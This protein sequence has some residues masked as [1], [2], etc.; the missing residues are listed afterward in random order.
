MSDIQLDG[1]NRLLKGIPVSEGISIAHIHVYNN[2]PHR[3]VSRQKIKPSQIK[4]EKQALKAAISQAIIDLEMLRGKVQVTLDE[5]H[6][7]IFDPQI[8]FLQDQDFLQRIMER[9]TKDRDNA[10]WSLM[11]EIKYFADQFS[12]INDEFLA[13]RSSDILDVGN[14]VCQ[15]LVADN[16]NLIHPLHFNSNV[17]VA[18]TDLSPSDTAQM[19]HEHVK[20]FA[21]ELG[22]PT[23]HTAILAK[24]LEIPAVVGL[25][26]SIHQLKQG[27]FVI[28]NGYDG[29]VTLDPT[30]QEIRRAKAQHRRHLILEKDLTKLKNLPAETIDGYRVELSANIELEIEIPH[31]FEHGAEGVGLFRT[32]FHYLENNDIPSEGDLFEVYRNVVKSMAPHPVIFRT[33]DLGGDKFIRDLKTGKEL[34]P[35]LGLRAIRLSLSRPEMFR[36]QLKAILRASSFG[37]A[38]IMFP[39]ISNLGEVHAAREILDNARKELIEEGHDFD[40][41]IQTGIMIEIPSAA[42]CADQ[43]A[44]E[45]DF[46]SIGSNDLIQYTLAVDRGNEQVA[47]LYDPFHPAILRLLR[48][49]VSAANREGI[50]VGVCGEMASDPLCA[51]L[52]VG[53]GVD[54]LSMGP[55]AV[56]RIKRLIRQIR[57]ADARRITGDIYARISS[58]DLQDYV[59]KS[60]RLLQRKRRPSRPS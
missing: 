35:F 7:A 17:I 59:E 11:H 52:L 13:G 54:E 31:V 2:D 22:G 38:R 20:G 25:G 33:F 15:Y 56:P 21:T 36:A 44:R 5:A 4:K 50:W 45:V 40:K 47:S 55:S 43:L 37:N 23:S 53:L 1:Q 34:N 18:C 12:A 29:T 24:A 27:T 60:Y 16:E 41:D 28:I 51:V 9:I 49:I 58:P 57:L 19:D 46:F 6:A 14:R 10:A 26:D 42:V 48:N 3:V 32:E 30:P 39:L 8:L